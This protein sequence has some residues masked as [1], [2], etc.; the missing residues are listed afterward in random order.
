MVYYLFITYENI[1]V[2]Y[3][4]IVIS[5]KTGNILEELCDLFN[6]V[7]YSNAKIIRM[8]KLFV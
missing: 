6:C 8:R 7:N 3:L 5:I 2:E 1:L 4:K